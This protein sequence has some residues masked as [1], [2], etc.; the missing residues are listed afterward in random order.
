MYFYMLYFAYNRWS[1]SK[2]LKSKT[3][4]IGSTSTSLKNNNLLVEKTSFG[5]FM[6]S[7]I[8]KSLIFL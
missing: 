8:G 5:V 7:G 1:Y 6:D 3:N 2:K 4:G